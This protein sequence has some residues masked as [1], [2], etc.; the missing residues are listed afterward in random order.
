MM[1]EKEKLFQQPPETVNVPSI[2]C[3]SAASWRQV[4]NDNQNSST[5][6][7]NQLE[8]VEQTFRRI[9]KK[10]VPDN[11]FLPSMKLFYKLFDTLLINI[12]SR[13]GRGCWL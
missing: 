5:E 12:T 13:R 10:E 4:N 11:N 7:Q 8:G 6:T 9:K 3:L 1:N 2:F